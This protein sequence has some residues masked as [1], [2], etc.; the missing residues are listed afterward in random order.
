MAYIDIGGAAPELTQS[1]IESFDFYLNVF[2]QSGDSDF[3]WLDAVVVTQF[4]SAV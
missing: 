2:S 4:Q 3:Y 1:Y